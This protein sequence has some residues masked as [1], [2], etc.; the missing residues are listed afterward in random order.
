MSLLLLGKCV[1]TSLGRGAAQT[2]WHMPETSSGP[3]M[4]QMTWLLQTMA[5]QPD[6]LPGP[7]ARQWE[8]V[9][10]WDSLFLLYNRSS[11][12]ALVFRDKLFLELILKFP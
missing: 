5:T 11:F 1:P 8:S 3:R 2:V 9:W 10:V 6:C 7:T 4:H 12:T